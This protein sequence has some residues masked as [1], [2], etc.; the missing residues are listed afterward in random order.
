MRPRS[1]GFWTDGCGSMFHV[2]RRPGG[3]PGTA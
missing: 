3:Q 2:K 1:A